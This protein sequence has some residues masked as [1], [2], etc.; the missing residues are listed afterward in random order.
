M[1][2]GSL[3]TNPCRT[4]TYIFPSR[5][6]IASLTIR[7]LFDESK[8]IEYKIEDDGEI[9]FSIPCDTVMNISGMRIRFLD[10]FEWEVLV[11]ESHPTFTFLEMLQHTPQNGI[12]YYLGFSSTS[13]LTRDCGHSEWSYRLW[14]GTGLEFLVQDC[15]FRK[16]KDFPQRFTRC[17]TDDDTCKTAWR[18]YVLMSPNILYIKGGRQFDFVTKK[19]QCSGLHRGLATCRSTTAF[20]ISHPPTYHCYLRMYVA[21]F[22]SNSASSPLFSKLVLYRFY[23]RLSR[24]LFSPLGAFLSR[25]HIT[26]NLCS[27]HK[28]TWKNC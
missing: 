25:M 19:L 23:G 15:P 28:G 7:R 13:D 2:V 8:G 10:N 12:F 18:R 27:I 14:E 20:S 6:K 1:S 24:I 5:R 9:K 4:L 21:S 3:L 26:L 22:H 17:I 16:L 11:M